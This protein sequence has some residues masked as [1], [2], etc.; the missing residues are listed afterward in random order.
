MKI[1]VSYSKIPGS[2]GNYCI[3][4]FKKIGHEV[5]EHDYL[6]I[7]HKYGIA[8]HSVSKFILKEKLPNKDLLKKVDEIKPDV[9]FILKGEVFYPKTLVKIKSK[10]IKIAN[11]CMDSPFH[12]LYS[13]TKLVKSIHLYDKFFTPVQL[14]EKFLK[15]FGFENSKF[16]PFA[17]D[18]DIHRT[19]NIMD[20]EKEYF[21]SDV[22][23]VGTH[24]PEREIL[25]SGLEKF[26][27]K[28][29]GNG[30]SNCLNSSVKKYATLKP[31]NNMDMVRV[32][33]A[34]K[35]AI[36]VHQEQSMDSPTMRVFEAPACGIFLITD[37]RENLRNF[38][39]TKEMVSYKNKKEMKDLLEYYL[40]NY[41][42]RKKMSRKAQK[43]SM[44]T[45]SYSNRM[46]DVIYSL[47]I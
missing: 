6:S 14:M 36:G 13:S 17:C 33:N 41:K 21:G 37:Y 19:I 29:W 3:N 42:E 15:K 47:K 26:N 30:W 27:L 44:G 34:S 22:C 8:G 31:A 9:V 4:A 2:L 40:E 43:K 45:H 16:L 7:P 11:W 32:F 5:F 18:P 28:I 24:Y 38:F 39:T 12:P 46:K 20:S 10:G 1:L 23:F 25:L 35:I